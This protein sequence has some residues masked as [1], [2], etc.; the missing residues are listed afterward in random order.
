[1]KHLFSKAIQDQR[2][3]ISS[4]P[5]GSVDL[6]IGL[7]YL[8]LDPV[9]VER[10]DNLRAILSPFEKG[11]IFAGY[12]SSLKSSRPRLNEDVAAIS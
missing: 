12:Y 9:D 2:E 7:D 3:C 4:R 6:L 1:M 10:L 11:L 5:I 8:S